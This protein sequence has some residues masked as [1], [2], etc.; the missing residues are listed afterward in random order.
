MKWE[1]KTGTHLGAPR[2]A[3]CVVKVKHQDGKRASLLP[4]R[5]ELLDL[6]GCVYLHTQVPL[7]I[8]HTQASPPNLPRFPRDIIMELGKLKQGF[9]ITWQ[10]GL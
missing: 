2:L 10:P 5:R 1:V 8:L 9:R 4:N 3:C 6:K 7:H